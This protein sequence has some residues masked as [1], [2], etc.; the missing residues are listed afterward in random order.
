[1]NFDQNKAFSYLEKLTSN[2]KDRLGGSANEKKAARYIRRHFAACGLK[3]QFQFFPVKTYLGRKKKLIITRPALG[4][5]DCE[6]VGLAANTSPRGVEAEI[7][8]VNTGEEE[9][10]SPRLEGKILLITGGV[11]Y[12]RYDA[13][14]KTRPAGIVEIEWEPKKPP[15]RVEIMPEWKTKWGAVPILRITHESGY[16][17]LRNKAKRARMIVDFAERRVQSLN[18][19]AELKGSEKP[20]EIV[21]IGGHYDTSP[22]IPGA[23]DNAGGTALVMELA[24]V[25]A[26]KGTKRTLRFVAWGSEELGLRGSI[27]YAEN[28]KT[29]DKKLKKTKSFVKTGGKTAL[30]KHR[31]CVNLDVHGVLIGGNES[32]VLGTHDLAASV[33]LLAKEMG[34]AFAVREEVYSSDGTPFSEAGVPSISFARSGGT[35]TY[36]HTP[37]DDISH[38]DA[39]ML[40]MHGRFIEAWLERYVTQAVSFPFER[41]VPDDLKKKIKEY[42]NERLGLPLE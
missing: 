14:M 15:I 17:L 42:F 29:T 27:F 35:S 21:V 13:V 20:E 39:S 33:R 31:L 19:I 41:T 3:T 24:R 37:M 6:L 4:E 36:L 23:S 11:P 2:F 16:R 10:L 7:V 18:V 22:G 34:P 32:L 28:L 1:M 30:D 40:G 12:K 9:Y 5:I 25:F 38:L 8:F 26:K